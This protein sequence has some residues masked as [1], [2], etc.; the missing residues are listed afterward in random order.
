MKPRLTA[1]PLTREDELI[2]WG[3]D[4][5]VPGYRYDL[6][7]EICRESD[8]R[9]ADLM[10]RAHDEFT[11]W[12]LRYM[13]TLFTELNPPDMEGMPPIGGVLVRGDQIT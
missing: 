1:A 6:V 13:C 10:F 8:R 7:S 5:A 12:S 11:R 2:W 3:L 9:D 4:E